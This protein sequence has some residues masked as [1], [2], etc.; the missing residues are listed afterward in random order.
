MGALA[1][2]TVDYIYITLAIFGVGK[3]LENIKFKKIFG[4]TSSLVLI[5]FGLFILKSVFMEH[6]ASVVATHTTNL[7]SSYV[8]VFF[9]TLSS[10][11]TIVF[12][13]SI[14]TAKTIEYNYTK[15]E[16]IIFGLGSGCM[17]L[18]F[19]GTAVLL[20][21]FLRGR[22]PSLLVSILNVIV[23]VLLIG[24]GTARCINNF[25]SKQERPPR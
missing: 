13:A 25:S 4:I 21:S 7:F 15:K 8:S 22:I 24:Y 3:L 18:I 23:G 17:T 10:P 11:L 14:F 6:V 19:L 9:L 5:V 1:A 2:T 12:F 20:F 16:L